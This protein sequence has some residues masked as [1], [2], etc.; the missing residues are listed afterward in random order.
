METTKFYPLNN[1]AAKYTD[2]I[3]LVVNTRCA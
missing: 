2:I 3:T 1:K